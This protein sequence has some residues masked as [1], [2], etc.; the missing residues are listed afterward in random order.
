MLKFN[1]QNK[2]SYLKS[3]NRTKWIWLSMTTEKVTEMEILD[4][5][6]KPCKWNDINDMQGYGTFINRRLESLGSIMY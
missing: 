2:I 4:I 5:K 6:N 3:Q 1:F